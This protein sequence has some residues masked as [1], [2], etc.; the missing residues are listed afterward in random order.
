MFVTLRKKCLGTG[1]QMHVAVPNEEVMAVFTLMRLEIVV[2]IYNSRDEAFI[3]FK[4][5]AEA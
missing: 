1:S 3:R 4:P 2:P 5:S